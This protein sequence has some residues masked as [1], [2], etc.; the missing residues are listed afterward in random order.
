MEQIY[1]ISSQRLEGI[2]DQARRLGNSAGKLT[3]GQMQQLLEGVTLGS[4][5]D[6]F[7]NFATGRLPVTVKGSVNSEITV[8]FTT[9]IHGTVMEEST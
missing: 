2:A 4:G 1:R 3:P 9:E 6:L 7:D 8:H 5:G